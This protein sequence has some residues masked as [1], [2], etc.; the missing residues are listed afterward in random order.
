[1]S[2][3]TFFKNFSPIMTLAFFGTAFSALV[4]AI[5]LWGMSQISPF[6]VSF[7]EAFTFG[8]LIS[9]TDPVSV[10]ATFN[11]VPVNPN[12]QM[13]IFGESALNDA[14]AI[15]L[16]RFTTTY[17]V[18]GAS[19]TGGSFFVTL[20]AILGVFF[21]SLVVGVLVA[22]L[23]AIILKHINVRESHGGTMLEVVLV[24]IFGYSSYL[25]AEL[26]YLS[27]IVSILFCGAAMANYTVPN[28]NKESQETTKSV[29]RLLAFITETALFIYLGLGLAAFSGEER[30][31]EASFIFISIF[32]MLVSRIH[33]FILVPICNL[34]KGE[35][36]I[37]MKQMVFI[38]YAGL[39]GGVCFVLGLDLLEDENYSK[40]FRRSVLV[41][42]VFFGR[43][44]EATYELT[45]AHLL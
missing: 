20:L 7:L 33:V 28:M 13:I 9:A 15:I 14:V 30:K 12:L 17:A 35:S 29:L 21:G 4:T 40:E 45:S 34:W 39:R 22:F 11:E 16:Y 26:A 19:F 25:V 44:L 27:G 41:S 42:C 23:A 10:L 18:P 38:W 32:A 36:K 6:P 37:S 1:M 8:S 24:I 3:S 2:R 43:F 5:I 31:F